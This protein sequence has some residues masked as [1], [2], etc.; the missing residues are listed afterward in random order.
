MKHY[1]KYGCNDF[2]IAL[3]YKS[4]V[5][6]EYFLNYYT[7]NN[8]FSVDLATGKVDI[9]DI[10]KLNWKVTLAD[11]GLNTMTGG[12]LKKM[13]NYIGNNT[14]LMSYG[15]G[16]SDVNIEELVKFHKNHGK[17]VTVTAVHPGARFGELV[18]DDCIVKRFEEKP[19]TQKGWINGS[20]LLLNQIFLI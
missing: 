12:R 4:E 17:M 5:I 6:K 7:L 18:L 14:F 2:Y 10:N 1:S 11:T 16:L 13:R 8:D 19:Q 15:D 20:F 9:N 3:G